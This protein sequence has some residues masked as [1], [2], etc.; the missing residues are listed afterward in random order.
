MP[1]GKPEPMITPE[2][3]QKISAALYQRMNVSRPKEVS[4]LSIERL[5]RQFSEIMPYENFSAL[6]D[7]AVAIDGASLLSKVESQRGGYCFELNLMFACLLSDLGVEHAMHLGRVWL[8]DPEEAPPR[9]HGTNVIM[10]DGEQFIADVG[11]GGRAPRCLVPFRVDSTAID[12]GDG[13]D[14]PIRTTDG[15]THGI[16]I[17]RRIDG[18]WKKQFSLELL[19]AEASDIE[20]ANYYQ[21]SHPQSAFRKHLFVGKFTENGRIG[22]F[23]NRFSRRVGRDTTV[24]TI[25]ELSDLKNVIQQDFLLNP[26]DFEADLAKILHS[27]QTN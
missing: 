3:R 4:R 6:R 24:R 2:Y 8:R 26:T 9:N 5:R 1:I 21:G 12:D 14:E 15:G 22:L 13:E 25:T 11:F 20:V 7:G 16:M 27:T 23:D 17:E 19:A 18:S 10:I